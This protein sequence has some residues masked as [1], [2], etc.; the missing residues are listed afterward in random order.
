MDNRR[1][2]IKKRIE[3]RKQLN[4]NKKRQI[5]KGRETYF[6]YTEYQDP[7]QI[8]W[9]S[10][11]GM[12]RKGHP[13]FQKEVFL[14]KVFLSLCLVFAVALL[15]KTPVNTLEPMKNIVKQVM[16]KDFQFAKVVSWYENT[17]GHPLALFPVDDQERRN[18]SGEFALPANGVILETFHS[19]HQGVTFQTEKNVQVT[20]VQEGIVIFAGIKEDTGKTVVIQH[21]DTTETW[22]GKLGDIFVRTYDSIQAGESIG[23]V[24][25]SQTKDAGEFYFAVKKD[26]AFVDPVQVINIE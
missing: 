21:P 22:Y 15:Y 7:E 19:D 6:P 12:G 9:V 18:R 26:D 2:Q 1:K 10:L 14:M 17:F 25:S 23:I 8:P 20:A 3:K 5:K 11:E 24:S 4:R 13:L 16:E